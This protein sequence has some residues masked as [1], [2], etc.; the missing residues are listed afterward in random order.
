MNL[1]KFVAE[2]QGLDPRSDVWAPPI[3]FFE[4]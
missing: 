3:V 2:R 4:D 1:Q